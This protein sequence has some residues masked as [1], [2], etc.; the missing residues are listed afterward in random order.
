MDLPNCLPKMPSC[1]SFLYSTEYLLR[2]TVCPCYFRDCGYINEQQRLK[3]STF[4]A[5]IF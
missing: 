2:P 3:I 5:L 4:L 1:F